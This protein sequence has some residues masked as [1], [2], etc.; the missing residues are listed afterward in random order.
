MEKIGQPFRV[1]IWQVKPEKAAEF[2]AAWQSS[3]DWLALKLLDEGG[4][5]LLED[6]NDPSRFI[7]FAPVNDPEKVEEVLRSAEF[8]ELWARV[9]RLCQDARP[10]RMRVVG[11]AG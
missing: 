8:Q 2:V 6:L 5:V 3:A 7:S 4:A 10:N 11:A 1:G 9:M